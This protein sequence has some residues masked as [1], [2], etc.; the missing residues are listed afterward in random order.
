MKRYINV[1]T[2]SKVRFCCKHSTTFQFYSIRTQRWCCLFMVY[3]GSMLNSRFSSSS[4]SYCPITLHNFIQCQWKQSNFLS[5]VHESVFLTSTIVYSISIKFSRTA[6]QKRTCL[7]GYYIAI[8]IIMISINRKVDASCMCY[9]G[10]T[11]VVQPL[12]VVWMSMKACH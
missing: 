6:Q 3:R 10:F 5:L 4:F 1:S 9:L 8:G 2:N 11:T 7:H 12:N